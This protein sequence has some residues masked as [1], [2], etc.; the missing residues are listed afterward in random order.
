MDIQKLLRPLYK[1]LK[2]N[3]T[4]EHLSLAN[5]EIDEYKYI[6]KLVMKNSVLR[7]L[8]IRGNYMNEDILMEF[9]VSLHNN[10]ELTDL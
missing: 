7:T 8:D 1:S 2:D 3:T 5:N 6:K 4:L 9:W 10:I